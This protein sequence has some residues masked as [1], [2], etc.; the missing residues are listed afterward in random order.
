VAQGVGVEVGE[1]EAAIDLDIVVEHGVSIA[2]I[3]DPPPAPPPPFRVP[4]GPPGRYPDPGL[5]PV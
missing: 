3:D 5:P 1:T 2:D 4:A